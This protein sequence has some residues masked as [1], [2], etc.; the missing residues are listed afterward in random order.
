MEFPMKYATQYYLILSNISHWKVH[1]NSTK[2]K[3]KF[4]DFT[5]GP[6]T[7]ATLFIM[8]WNMCISWDVGERV[9]TST[10]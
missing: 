3:L 10:P 8:N 6:T 2:S 7:K 4:L 1:K 5:I 9:L